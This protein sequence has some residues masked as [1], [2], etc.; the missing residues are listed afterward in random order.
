MSSNQTT[1]RPS[2]LPPPTASWEELEYERSRDRFL[3]DL[4]S[5]IPI[6]SVTV[7]SVH[8]SD[9]VAFPDDWIEHEDILPPVHERLHNPL[10]SLLEEKFVRVFIRRHQLNDNKVTVRVYGGPL[11]TYHLSN[12]YEL[13]YFLLQYCLMTWGENLCIEAT[14]LDRM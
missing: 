13:N 5:Y 6:G 2:A 14:K 10:L 11:Y 3:K 9:G 1:S 7:D 8:G 12:V 4:N